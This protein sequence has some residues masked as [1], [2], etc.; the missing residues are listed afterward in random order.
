MDSFQ[1]RKHKQFQVRE[2][3][4]ILPTFHVVLLVYLTDILFTFY[5][6]YKYFICAHFSD[7]FYSYSG[8]IFYED[9]IDILYHLFTELFIPWVFYKDYVHILKGYFRYVIKSL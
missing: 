1:E 6:Y 9:F 5:R 7:I 8:S 2:N 4:N 3:I